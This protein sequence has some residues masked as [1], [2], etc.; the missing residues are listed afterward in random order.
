M[1]VNPLGQRQM[2]QMANVE[3]VRQ[4]HMVSEQLQREAVRKEAADEKLE[5]DQRS[6]REIPGSERIRTEERQS[7][8][9]GSGT[10]GEED[11]G[12]PEGTTPESPEDQAGPAE[13]RL[14]FLA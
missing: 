1:V 3:A 7:K 10:K 9:G 6:V 14:D 2:F 5:E 13:N 11:A 12:E 8:G 4:A